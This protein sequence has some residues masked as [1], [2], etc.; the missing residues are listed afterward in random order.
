MFSHTASSGNDG[1]GGGTIRGPQSLRARAH[2]DIVCAFAASSRRVERRVWRSQRAPAVGPERAAGTDGPPATRPTIIALAVAC[3]A[4]AVVR[5]RVLAHSVGR[6]RRQRGRQH[7]WPAVTARA[8][9][10]IDIICASA[11]SSSEM[12][13]ARAPAV[14][15][16]RAVRANRILA[17]WPTIIALTITGAAVAVMIGTRVDAYGI[18]WERRQWWQRRW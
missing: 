12:R 14:A 9:G 6:E 15:A 2:S 4:A 13:C 8:Q 11:A 1:G 10:S 3:V 17:T 18:G 16:E 7:P 5:A